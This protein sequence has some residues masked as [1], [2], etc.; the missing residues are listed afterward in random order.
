LAVNRGLLHLL[1]AFIGTPPRALCRPKNRVGGSPVFL[2]NFVSQKSAKPVAASGENPACGYDFAS[3][4]HK[5]LYCKDGPV[6]GIDPLGYD[7][8]GLGSLAVAG[9]G[10]VAIDGF[11]LPAINW[12]YVSMMGTRSQR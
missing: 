6:N 5:Y 11:S 8:F 2:S 12:A 4:M 1:L 3:G 10:S 9:G 7:D